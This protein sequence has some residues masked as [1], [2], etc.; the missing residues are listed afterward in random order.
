M[1]QVTLKFLETPGHTPESVSI[2]VIDGEKSDDARGGAD[3]RHALHRRRR[4]AGPARLEGEPRG[5][6]EQAL[7]L[8]AREAPEAAG[9]DEG[10]SR[11]TARARSAA[12]TSRARRARRSASSGSSTTRCARCRA[13]S[14]SSS[15]RRICRRRRR[16][17]PATRRSTARGRAR[18]RRCRRR[19]RSRPTTSP[20]CRRRAPSCSTRVRPPSTAR[21]TCRA[22]S[23][24][25]SRASSPRGPGSLM[26]PQGPIVLVAEDE[27]RMGETRT[28]LARVGIENVSGY[29]AG[30]IRAWDAAG[31][32]LAKTEQIDVD[33]LRARLAEEERGP[34]A[35]GRAPAPRVEGR[36][37][38]AGRLDAAR[39][40]L[41]AR[42]DARQEA[43]RRRDL[44]RR[45]SLLDRHE[46]PRAA[47]VP[48][49]S[50]TSSAAWPPGPARSTKPS[51][52]ARRLG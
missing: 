47:R 36:P 52:Q 22:R 24:S 6:R 37:H 43:S 16:T 33:E 25:A 49:G 45:L 8:A 4:P 21:A 46:R 1:G 18:S 13:R 12:A 41:R 50:P 7:R 23:T 28:R 29:L 14:S 19:P 34:A 2:V 27:E 3:G 5:A 38:P 20:C 10:L 9:L 15:S 30:G 48:A 32:P 42:E 11:R 26:S 39:P 40:A 51:P 17:S 44:R 31:R 35:R